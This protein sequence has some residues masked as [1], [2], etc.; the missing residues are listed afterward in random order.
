MFTAEEKFMK[1]AIKEAIKS[2][3]KG[4]YA[5]GAVIVKNEKIISKSGNA[6]KINQ[7]SAHHAELIAIQKASKK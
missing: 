4:N 3:E 2:K 7:N 6:V 5:I 1:I